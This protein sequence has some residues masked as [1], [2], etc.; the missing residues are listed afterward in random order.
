MDD[1]DSNIFWESRR[2]LRKPISE[3]YDVAM[4]LNE[5]VRAHNTGNIEI[6]ENLIFGADVSVLADWA[7]SIWG[8]MSIKIHRYREVSNTSSAIMLNKKTSR[9][10]NSSIKKM[11]IERDGY[12]CRYC[13]IPVIR[14]EVRDKI[15]KLYP[16]ALRW[17][18]KNKERHAAFQ[19]L[20]LTYEHVIPFSQ[21][22]D[23]SFENMIISCQACNCGK[24]NATLEELGL[25]NPKKF[26][27]VK[28][29]WGG[30]ENFQKNDDKK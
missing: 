8:K 16:K 28:T 27:I 30:L 5:A 26:K 2:C 29:E 17:G 18:K 1:I 19:C 21:G 6:A 4:K 10:P 14:S 20:W 13:G 11:L 15:R 3:I 24:G 23:S 12:N 9:M 22:G 7:E 25:Y